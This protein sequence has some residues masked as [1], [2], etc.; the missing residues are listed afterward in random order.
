MTVPQRHFHPRA[1][2][3]NSVKFAGLI[4]RERSQVSRHK[5]KWLRSDNRCNR[6]FLRFQ[7]IWGPESFALTAD[8]GLLVFTSLMKP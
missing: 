1:G 8:G 4:T 3:L 6:G 7:Q 2:L 5:S